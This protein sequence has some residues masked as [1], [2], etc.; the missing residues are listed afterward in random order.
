MILDV[1][2][3]MLTK[4]GYRV[5]T[6][7]NGREAIHVMENHPEKIALVILDMIMPVMGGGETFDILKSKYPSLKFLL[8]SGYAVDG[9]A[10]E[11]LSRG[12]NG[13][14]QK[15]FNIEQLSQKTYQILNP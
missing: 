5:L 14:I 11:I 3:Q 15:P 2:S 12:C 9:Q 7:L 13:F 8:A 1:G 4:L 6:A 10:S